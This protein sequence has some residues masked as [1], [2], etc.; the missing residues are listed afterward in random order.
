MTR[1][2]AFGELVETDDGRWLRVVS[3]PDPWRPGCYRG[4]DGQIRTCP[5]IIDPEAERRIR[6]A[7]PP[8]PPDDPLERY[9]I[10]RARA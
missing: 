8:P 2:L 1:P 5:E 3:T 9:I 6:N 7:P 4:R 10:V